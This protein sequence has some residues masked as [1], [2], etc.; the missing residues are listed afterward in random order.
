MSPVIGLIVN[1]VAGIGGPAA[2]KG[3]DGADVQRRAI[4]TGAVPRSG[5]RAAVTVRRLLARLPDL[6]L[7]AAP[8]R[9]GERAALDCGV[10]GPRL[11]V[12]IETGQVTTGDD[13]SR[14]AV[15]M[16]AAGA[17]LILFAGGDGTARDLVRGVSESVPVLGIPAGV[18]MQSAVFATSPVAAAEVAIAFL[19]RG[20]TMVRP[21][22]VVDI[23]EDC[24]RAGRLTARLHG[25]LA[26]PVERRRVQD[27]K[28]G[29][30]QAA[31]GTAAD[32]AAAFAAQMEPGRLYVLG[33]GTTMRAVADHLGIPKT[34]LGVD[35]VTTAGLVAADVTARDLDAMVS[36][37][38]TIAVSPI[39]G[40]GFIFGR[41]N[42]QISATALAAVGPGGIAVLCT[43][44]KL[45]GLRGAPLLVDTGDPAVDAS[46][47]GHVR[48]ITGR[49]ERTIYRTRA[50]GG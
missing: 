15:A 35:V 25:H 10:A 23:D 37:G 5:E 6:V 29:S 26:V 41:G 40:Q 9:M 18:K 43:H 46:L 30:S 39:G 33:P 19:A 17:E 32:V 22:E 20:G 4:R 49:N 27:R 31:A 14:A 36:A 21:R 28:T 11:R 48:V 50:A 1:P 42:Q 12:V 2:L 45:A 38:T 16:R 8:D 13:T 47:A 24:L 44:E 34:L 7:L 3:S